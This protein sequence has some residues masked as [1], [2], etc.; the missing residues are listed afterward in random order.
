L[1]RL[2]LGI[3][4]QYFDILDAC[5]EIIL[6]FLPP[7]STPTAPFKMMIGGCLSEAAFT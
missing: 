7:Q 6:Y 5:D 1:S 2:W 3:L 4:D